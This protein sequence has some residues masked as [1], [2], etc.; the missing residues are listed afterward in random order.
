MGGSTVAGP[1]RAARTR[2]GATALFAV[3]TLS[4]GLAAPPASAAPAPPVP[5]VTL[6]V[7]L[8]NAS[9][10]EAQNVC[11]PTPRP[12]ALALRDLLIR[13]YGAATIYLGRTCTS[14]TSEH[15]DGRAVDWMRDSRV[16]AQ[17]EMADSFVDWLL[18]PA[19]DG[20]PH[21]MARRLGIMYMIWNN[22][23]IR[24]YDPGRGWTDYRSCMAP[25]NSA[26][27]LDTGCHRNH[28]HLSM[29]WDGAGAVT[30]W[31]S[32]VAQVLPFCPSRSTTTTPGAGA[33]QVVDPASLPTLVPVAPE[34]VLDTAAGIGA[35]PGCRLLA[36][37]VLYPQVRLRTAPVGAPWAVISAT[38]HSNAPANLLAWSSGAERP[39][40]LLGSPIGSTSAT[41]AVPIAADGTIAVATS[42]GA[43][44]VVIQVIGY[45]LTEPGAPS[46]VITPPTSATAP[47]RP[48]DVAAT[49]PRGRTITVRWQEPA[50]SGSAAVASYRARA[51]VKAKKGARAAGS[52]TVG[53]QERKCRIRGLK[54]GR[55]YWVVVVARTPDGVSRSRRNAVTVR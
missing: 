32:G 20:T 12:G 47:S 46:P 13:T 19:A 37:R 28:V 8:D 45:L 30:S 35:A 11:D 42:L 49:S 14:S 15:F 16:P 3:L 41:L 39:G 1:A 53:P 50:D 29:S 5:T 48:R 34:T 4:L 17:K 27:A 51:L 23:M 25:S 43:A 38:T 18:A 31:W 6:P 26:P 9:F 24:M 36:G 10:Y 54:A 52:C 40:Q 2:L 21:A 22:R 7:A 33:P 55:K 44:R